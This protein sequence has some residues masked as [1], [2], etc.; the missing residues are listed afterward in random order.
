MPTFRSRR[1]LA[2]HT[3]VGLVMG[4]VLA[5]C[6]ASG[7]VAGSAPASNSPRTVTA[8]TSPSPTPADA[9]PASADVPEIEVQIVDGAVRTEADTVEVAPGEAIRIVVTSDVDDE[10]H[11]HGVDQT[12]VLVAGEPTTLELVFDES[13]VFEVETH[14]GGVLLL[15]LSVR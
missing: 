3:L 10:L 8:P 13:G 1:N 4:A 9:P 7:E 6:G 12:A 15:Q 2:L 5:G 11:V 14:D